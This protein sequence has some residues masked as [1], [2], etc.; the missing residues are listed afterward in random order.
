MTELSPEQ[1]QYTTTQIISEGAYGCAVYPGVKCDN[2]SE[3]PN[4]LTKVQVDG[5]MLQNENQIGQMIIEKYGN[6]HILFYAPILASCN[7]EAGEIQND[8]IKKCK[9]LQPTTDPTDPTAATATSTTTTYVNSKIRYIGK[10]SLNTLFKTLAQSP[11]NTQTTKI[12]DLYLYLSKSIQMLQDINLVHFDLK[13]NNIMYDHSHHVPIMID[14][15]LTRKMPLTF[16]ESAQFF[17]T[18]DKYIIWSIEIFL[19]SRI[20]KKQSSEILTQ[21]TTQEL[22]DLCMTNIDHPEGIYK[23]TLFN[24]AEVETYKATIQTFLNTYTG[25]SYANL[26]DKLMETYKTWDLYSISATF[27]FLIKVYFPT[28]DTDTAIQA[29]QPYITIFKSHILA[30][31]LERESIEE[32]IKK[33]QTL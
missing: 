32:T 30:N 16:D 24:P 15:G 17:Q 33:I 28:T 6:R 27:L 13:D 9:I 23:I 4:Y 1:R 3:G 12:A 22:I 21:Q 20:S 18:Y 11:Q 10:T 31:P 7:I 19:I 8:E 25:Y 2:T 26:H 14:F 5:P 29:I